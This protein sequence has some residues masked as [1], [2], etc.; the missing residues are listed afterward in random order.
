[1]LQLGN[2]FIDTRELFIR[3]GDLF[4]RMREPFI[5]ARDQLYVLPGQSRTSTVP[6][7]L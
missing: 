1:M 4:I 3:A 7:R 6:Q 2:L 5:G